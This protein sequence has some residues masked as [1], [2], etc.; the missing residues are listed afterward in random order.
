[1]RVA[2]V[3]EL[4]HR[5]EIEDRPVPT[6]GARQVLV[7]LEA[8]GL[9]H[10]DIHAAHGDWPVTPT[11]SWPGTNGGVGVTGQSPWAAWMSVWHNPDA[12]RRTRT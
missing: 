6:P 3:P 4:G 7:R 1:M 8:S 10:T 5:L 12:S 2:V 9:F 11:P